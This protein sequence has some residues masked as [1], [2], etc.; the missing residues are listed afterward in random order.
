MTDYVISTNILTWI[1]V[2]SK[3]PFLGWVLADKEAEVIEQMKV[4]DL[5]IPKYAQA[6]TY[7]D[8]EQM[9]FAEEI[10]EALGED[11]QAQLVAYENKINAG[12]LGAGA[13]PHVLRAIRRPQTQEELP[14]GWSVI[15]VE[16]INLENPVSTSEFQR[17]RGISL[18]IASQLK[19]TVGPGKHIQRVREGVANEVI[20]AGSL[21]T[22]GPEFLKRLMLVKAKDA[23]EARRVLQQT[24]NGPDSEDLVFVAS[25]NDMAG[26]FEVDAVG[27]LA[28]TPHSGSFGDSADSVLRQLEDAKDRPDG[29]DLK[30]SNAIRAAERL[31]QFMEESEDTD[32]I[33]NFPFF[34]NGFA[35]L[36]EKTS[37]AMELLASPI[38]LEEGPPELITEGSADSP[39][40]STESLS[41]LMLERIKGLTVSAVE[42]QLGDISLP[43]QTI[44]DAVTALRA[45]KHLLF[46]GPPGT[47]KS[48]FASALSRTVVDSGYEVATATAD[49]TTFDTIGGYMPAEGGALIFEEGVVL[50]ALKM[51]NWLIIDEINR[52]D[53]DKAFGPLFTILS[54]AGEHQG[55]GEEVVLPYRQEGKTT[56]IVW[57]N[58][59]DPLPHEYPIT[60]AWRLLGTLNVRDKASLFKLSFAFLRRFAVIDVPLPSQDIYRGLVDNWLQLG[61]DQGKEQVLD[62]SMDLAFG[63]V[64]L[65]PA[66]LKDISAFTERGLKDLDPSKQGPPYDSAQEAFVA[67]VRLYAVPQ[68]EGSPVGDVD[69]L[70]ASLKG[71]LTDVHLQSWER[72]EGALREV[73]LDFGDLALG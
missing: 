5:I 16:V 19:A 66:I 6:T 12:E 21:E 28:Q 49:W 26:F 64:E 18:S 51:S 23:D 4:G 2:Q 27:R 55:A 14:G 46:S 67:A 40:E 57:S 13:V 38:S 58:G 68:Y 3:D 17:F 56:K 25:T 45:G 15:D 63:P 65:G 42:T 70:M 36:A 11:L 24:G 50:R 59:G 30:L 62:A 47:G 61:Q 9:A 10:C 71:R 34:Y 22:R 73:T 32:A 43:R 8:T 33:R 52:A 29:K 41:D 39:D 44:A 35:L 48:R 31:T 54:G 72:L 37:R 20:R 1:V 69:K 60:P 53:I 7:A